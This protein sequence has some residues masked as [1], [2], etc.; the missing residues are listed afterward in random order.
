M[1]QPIET[2]PKDETR[3]L[4]YAPAAPKAVNQN[5]QVPQMRVDRRMERYGGRYANMLPEAPYT[6][7]MPL[8]APP[9]PAQ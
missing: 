6:H 1:W 4:L 5:A 2:A 7:W 9:E 3:V 8:P